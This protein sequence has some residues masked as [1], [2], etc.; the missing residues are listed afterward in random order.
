MSVWNA[1]SNKFRH[2]S[3][4]SYTNNANNNNGNLLVDNL[5]M[6]ISFIWVCFSKFGRG[7][8]TTNVNCDL[9]H[10]IVVGL[11][12]KSHKSGKKRLLALLFIGNPFHQRSASLNYF[13]KK[14]LSKFCGSHDWFACD[15]HFV[16]E[17]FTETYQ[18]S[19]RRSR[20]SHKLSSWQN[21]ESIFTGY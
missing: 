17:N 14:I 13:F 5:F 4:S 2:F 6:I 7:I 8:Q 18:M 19:F 1:S 9:I 20:R 10:L 16:I 11:C 21:W 3:L 15:D 12:Q